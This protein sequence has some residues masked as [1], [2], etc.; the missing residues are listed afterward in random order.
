M[1]IESEKMLDISVSSPA[2]AAFAPDDS[3]QHSGGSEVP[4]APEVIQY[5]TQSYLG[6]WGWV[7]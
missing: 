7:A 3:S 5:P 2:Q 1:D 4:T 6:K